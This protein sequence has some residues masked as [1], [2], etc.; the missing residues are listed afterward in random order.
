MDTSLVISQHSERSWTLVLRTNKC[1]HP[2]TILAIAPGKESL[3]LILMYT[4]FSL[5]HS[6][7]FWSRKIRY[8]F[9][10]YIIKDKPYATLFR[11]KRFKN[12][13]KWSKK[14]LLNLPYLWKIKTHAAFFS[15][16]INFFFFS[17][18]MNGTPGLCWHWNR[19]E[20]CS[21]SYIGDGHRFRG[22]IFLFL[23]WLI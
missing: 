4:F 18:W 13:I 19:F 5:H 12:L 16:S 1:F 20:I 2:I 11:N 6:R 15:L 10:I 7:Y 3:L 23:F 8:F 17:K 21:T 9:K 14:I 22:I